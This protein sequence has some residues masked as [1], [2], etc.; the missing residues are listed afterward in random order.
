VGWALLETDYRDDPDDPP[1]IERQVEGMIALTDSV[2]SC[3]APGLEAETPYLFLGYD[4]DE[5]PDPSAWQ[6][7][8]EQVRRTQRRKEEAEKEAGR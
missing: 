5:K 6:E 2:E 4:H 8:A 1:N 3:Q 7:Q